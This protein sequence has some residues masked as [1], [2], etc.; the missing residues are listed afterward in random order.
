VSRDRRRPRH[1]R[2]NVVPLFPDAREQPGRVVRLTAG[3]MLT[4]M[5]VFADAI[6]FRARAG[7]PDGAESY[8]ALAKVLGIEVSR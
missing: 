6:A 4:L 7:D 8:A 3:Q 2:G 5:D 1:D